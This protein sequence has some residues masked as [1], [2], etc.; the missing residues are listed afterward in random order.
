MA[1][2]VNSITN[3]FFVSYSLVVVVVLRQWALFICC[4]DMGDIET[5]NVAFI[6]MG[7]IESNVPKDN[8]HTSTFA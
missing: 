3:V 5:T 7:D 6:D 1:I 8:L 4:L 2:N